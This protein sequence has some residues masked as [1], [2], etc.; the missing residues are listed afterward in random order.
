MGKIGDAPLIEG[1]LPPIL[2]PSRRAA[3]LLVGSP[4]DKLSAS[5]KVI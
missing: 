5:C 2:Q 1:Y 4:L 3:E